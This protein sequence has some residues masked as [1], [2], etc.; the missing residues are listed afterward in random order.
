M[1]IKT[2]IEYPDSTINPSMGC[3]GCELYNPSWPN[4]KQHCYAA[5]MTKIYAGNKGWPKDFSKPEL[6][7]H[8]VKQACD[9]SDLTGTDRPD[10]PWLNG[11]PR[12]IFWGDMG[13]MFDGQLP[14]NW[15]L[16]HLPAI[17]ANPHINLFLTKRP[18]RMFA[19]FDD[20]GGVPKNIWPGT[21]VTNKDT[22]GRIDS[23]T[24]LRQIEPD[25]K[26]WVSF[27]PLLGPVDDYGAVFLCE[28]LNW[29]VVGGESGNRARHME[30]WW[31]EPV[32]NGCKN[33]GIPF[34]M[35]QMSG[36][37]KA[38]LQ[39]IPEDLQIREFPK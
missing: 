16:P 4:E 28:G 27:E 37:N 26:L 19:L 13:D 18:M 39:A 38:L 32:K 34:F 20:Y 6:F 7:E 15:L 2:K 33:R 23:L 3:S 21:T 22:V 35:K 12:V 24:D 8:R 36:N 31:V 25:V 17:E 29:V 14:Y 10:K 5:I 1:G 30:S 11:S 9:W